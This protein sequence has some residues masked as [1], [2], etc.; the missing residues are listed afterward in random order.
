MNQN[1]NKVNFNKFLILK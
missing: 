1:S